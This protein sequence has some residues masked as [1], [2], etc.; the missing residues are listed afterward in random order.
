M[1]KY[2]RLCL[3]FVLSL[4]WFLANSLPPSPSYSTPPL[5]IGTTSPTLPPHASLLQYGLL[6]TLS[7]LRTWELV[8]S[9]LT[10]APALLSCPLYPCTFAT[11]SYLPR[12]FHLPIGSSSA[13]ILI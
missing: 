11:S 4:L 13:F 10:S 1:I 5:R 3:D 9:R 6:A 12:T 7:G 8:S 2:V